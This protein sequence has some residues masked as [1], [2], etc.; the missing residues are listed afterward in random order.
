MGVSAY[1]SAITNGRGMAKSNLYSLYFV[2][3]QMDQPWVTNQYGGMSTKVTGENITLVGQRILIMC[4]EVT[5]PGVQTSTGT[6]NRFAGASPV[7]FPSGLVYNDLQLSFM[8][9][10]EMQA[11]N[12]LQEWM[13]KLYQTTGTTKNKSYRFNYLD[14]FS[15]EK[16]VIEKNERN[17]TGEVAL[18]PLKYYIY[19]AWPYAIDAVPLSYGSS[20]LVKVT[21]NFY[22]T[23]WESF[24]TRLP[25]I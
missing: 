6:V 1:V 5:L 9:D 3:G 20:Q 10:A 25:T 22:Y 17:A 13:T 18:T 15:C 19:R 24:A 21:A 23:N 8:C 2:G 12:F 16:I 7:A 14:E 11:L 4:D